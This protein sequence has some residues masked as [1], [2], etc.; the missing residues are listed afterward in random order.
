MKKKEKKKKK[1]EKKNHYRV[2]NTQIIL[3]TEFQ[4][5]L[6]ILTFWA[7]FAQEGYFL[8]KTEKVNIT[9]EWCVFE[10]I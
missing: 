2:L 7:K 5:K 1:K 8:P 6:T 3:C 4:L 10:L 9:T